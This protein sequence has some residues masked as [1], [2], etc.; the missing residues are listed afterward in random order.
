MSTLSLS[1]PTQRYY[2]IAV[3]AFFFIQGICFA[4][5]ASRIPDI[6][7][8]LQLTD[9]Q[10][11][12]VLLGLP[13]GQ[14]TAMAM[15]GY[16]V[17]KLGS[18]TTLTIGSLIYPAVLVLIGSVTNVWQL[19]ASL[20]LFGVS[21]NLTNISVNTQAVG[22]ERLYRRSIMASFHGIWSLAGFTGG[23]ISTL[24]VA[25]NMPPQ[26]HFMMIYLLALGIMLSA[27]R[28]V[29]PRDAAVKAVKGPIFV[30]PDAAILRLGLIAFACM[31]CEGTMFDWSGIYFEKV[32]NVPKDLTRVGY[33]A[34][35]CTMASGRLL[36]DKWVTKFGVQNI[37][38]A[39]DIIILASLL[40][41]V[42]F[43][44]LI[45]ATIGFLLVGIGV[46][47]VVPM[48]YSLAGKSKTMLPGVALAAVSSIGFLGFLLGPP[49]I[50][51]IAEASSL[52][53]SFAV[54]A[55]LGFGTT[56]LAGK[57]KTD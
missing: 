18:K 36:A 53:V 31:V 26:Q 12:G 11:G 25:K 13:L 56:V 41:A 44:Y 45:P 43:P 10:L 8:K 46:S 47:S 29:L 37:L 4:S 27:R 57:V 21:G 19:T 42:I 40:L 52:R 15:S 5:W 49:I 16:L 6:K 51:F 55:V 9:G 7:N 54:I 35:M 32:L 48:T 14:L 30:K 17:S 2:R 39:S 1:F 34:F 33:V 20:F 22:V 50:G 24:M 3:S 38:K 28:F 23:L